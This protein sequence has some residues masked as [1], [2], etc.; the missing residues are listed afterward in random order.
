MY[1]ASGNFLAVTS[2]KVMRWKQ[3][4]NYDSEKDTDF[5]QQQIKKTGPNNIMCPNFC[6]DHIKK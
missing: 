3:Q 5:Y 2:F 4:W 6:G 1:W